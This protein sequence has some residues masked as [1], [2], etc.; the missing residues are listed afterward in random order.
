VEK[1]DMIKARKGLVLTEKRKNEREVRKI[2]LVFA[3]RDWKFV[4]RIV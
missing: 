4:S 1:V 2:A 3:D